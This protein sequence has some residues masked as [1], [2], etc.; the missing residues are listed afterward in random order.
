MIKAGYNLNEK[1]IQD[2]YSKITDEITMPS[3][4]YQ[5]VTDLALPQH[6]EKVL[7]LGC[8]NGYLLEIFAHRYPESKLY[9]TD[10]SPALVELARNRLNGKAKINQA[11]ANDPLPFDDHFFDIIT[12]TDVIEHLKEP[13]KVLQQMKR[14]LRPDGRAII[15]YPCGSL[16]RLFIPFAEK[17]PKSKVAR[18]FLPPEHPLRTFQPIDT[19][20]FWREMKLLLKKNG[21]EITSAVGRE[22]FRYL[23]EISQFSKYNYRLS[24]FLYKAIEKTDRCLNWLGI[25][26]LCYRIVLECRIA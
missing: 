8:G 15:T 23:Y 3:Y 17:F 13:D 6:G 20:Y 12:M 9:G 7:D 25:I 18:V 24:P 16:Y 19:V 4:F 26:N 5:L 1:Q 2:G 22:S 11:S 21:F 14:I 10:L